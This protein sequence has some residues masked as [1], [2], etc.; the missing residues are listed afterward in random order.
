M[1]FSHQCMTSQGPKTAIF[2]QNIINS[3]IHVC[4][5]IIVS[6]FKRFSGDTV[7]SNENAF[8]YLDLN[9]LV[10]VLRFMAFQFFQLNS[11][12]TVHVQSY[13]HRSGSFYLSI[14]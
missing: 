12:S 10:V 14:I 9:D 4:K 3:D 2:Q 11:V 8:I 13:F 6:F 1:V 7:Q 5:R